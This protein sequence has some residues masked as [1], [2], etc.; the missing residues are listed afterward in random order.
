MPDPVGFVFYDQ[1]AAGFYRW[2]QMSGDLGNSLL[3]AP[4]LQETMAHGTGVPFA[5][6]LLALLQDIG[7]GT[8]RLRAQFYAGYTALID[9]PLRISSRMD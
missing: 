4:A 3:F 6:I 1:P 5:K 2:D 8:L 7:S 9:P